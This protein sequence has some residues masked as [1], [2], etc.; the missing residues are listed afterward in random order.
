M[1]TLC[2]FRGEKEDCRQVGDLALLLFMF[3]YQDVCWSVLFLFLLCS[4]SVQLL[5][6]AI[7]Q[8][9]DGECL[10]HY[11]GTAASI[12]LYFVIEATA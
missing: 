9:K 8:H 6:P 7:G 4:K 3:D 10:R 11:S 12:H 5:L 1:T 2:V